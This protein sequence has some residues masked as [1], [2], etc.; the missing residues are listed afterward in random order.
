MTW[1]EYPDE[2][3]VEDTEDGEEDL[4]VCPSCRAKV[5]EDTQQCPQCGDWI[6]PVYPDARWKRWVW[7]V[8]VI[9][10]VLA[11]ILMA[12]PI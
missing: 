4:M 7:L 1:N 12:V 2:E 11:F 6:V 8:A 10:I 5:H 9:L 3:W